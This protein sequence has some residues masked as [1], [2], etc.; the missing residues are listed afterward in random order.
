[1][2][3]PNCNKRSHTTTKLAW[4]CLSG[5]T[6]YM[7]QT[8][9]KRTPR[10]VNAKCSPVNDVAK[11]SPSERLKSVL[12]TKTMPTAEQKFRAISAGVC[13]E[14]CLLTTFNFTWLS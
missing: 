10:A 7:P 3:D 6:L 4:I 8:R 9:H 1:M 14:A 12:F 11:P 5:L 13:R 2:L